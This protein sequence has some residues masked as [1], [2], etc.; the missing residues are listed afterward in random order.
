M[1]HVWDMNTV[2]VTGINGSIGGVADDLSTDLG[3]NPSG[4]GYIN[5]YPVNPKVPQ[6]YLFVGYTYG[7]TSTADFLAESFS[8]MIYHPEYFPP[9]LN[10]EIWVVVTIQLEASLIP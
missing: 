6:N 4:N 8:S 10:Q 7:N 2:K 5:I 9:G 3:G 1:G